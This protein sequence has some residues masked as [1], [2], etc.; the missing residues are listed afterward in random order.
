M[1]KFLALVTSLS[2]L[3]STP[4]HADSSDFSIRLGSNTARE[5]A[6]EKQLRRLLDQYDVSPYSYTYSILINQ[7]DVPHSHP[8]LTLNTVHLG[9]DANTLSTFLHEQ[10]H[11]F[12]LITDAATK[13]TIADLKQIYPDVPVGRGLGAR[14]EYSTYVHLIVCW[15]EYEVLASYLGQDA[16]ARILGSKRHYRWI[17]KQVLENTDTLRK[18]LEKHGLDNPA[19]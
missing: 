17:Y 19:I 10:F 12:S 4:L 7:G 9:D 2:L 16:A 14:D 13:A 1:T 18:L 11:W 5:M 6:T 3:V 8:V 15:Q